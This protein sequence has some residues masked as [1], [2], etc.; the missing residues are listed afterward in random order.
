M[1]ETGDKLDMARSRARELNKK[2]EALRAEP[3]VNAGIGAAAAG[4]GGGA[5]AVINEAMGGALYTIGGDA[6]GAGGI[7]LTAGMGVGVLSTVLGMSEKSATLLDV[8]K[9]AIGYEVGTMTASYVK[10]MFK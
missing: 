1:A 3:F 9:G 5:A 10:G 7:G 8:G 4:L 2:V 6:N